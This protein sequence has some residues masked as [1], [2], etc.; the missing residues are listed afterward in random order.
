[1]PLWRFRLVARTH[2]SH[3]WNTG[4]IPVGATLVRTFW[5]L[6]FC[7]ALIGNTCCSHPALHHYLGA[8]CDYCCK[9]CRLTAF[10]KL[11][12]RKNRPRT[13]HPER[14][15]GS[16]TKGSL[17]I[18]KQS[19]RYQSMRILRF[20]ALLLFAP[21]WQSL[22]ITIAIVISKRNRHCVSNSCC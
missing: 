18:E 15:E 17:K 6:F 10:R 8:T 9:C 13:Y 4:S 21:E 1:M 14:S 3:A 20:F 12:V 5:V 11:P 19:Q 7:L 22:K 16:Q 2:A